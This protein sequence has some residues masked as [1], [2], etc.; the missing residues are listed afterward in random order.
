MKQLPTLP[1]KKEKT[2]HGWDNHAMHCM[3]RSC[4]RI[5]FE[6]IGFNGGN[7]VPDIFLWATLESKDT[8]ASAGGKRIS[9]DKPVSQ[10]PGDMP[11]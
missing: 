2:N 8:I 6:N 11:P 9:E 5:L 3:N 10:E 7:L 1:I 4:E